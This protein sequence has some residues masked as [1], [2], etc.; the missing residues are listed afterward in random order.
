M[1][2]SN[3]IPVSWSSPC[4]PKLPGHLLPLFCSTPYSSHTQL[5]EFLKLTFLRV[6]PSVCHILLQSPPCGPCACLSFKIQ[7]SHVCADPSSQPPDVKISGSSQ[8]WHEKYIHKWVV[9]EEYVIII[10]TITTVSHPHCRPR[11]HILVTFILRI[12]NTPWNQAS[13]D[14]SGKVIQEL[15]RGN[16]RGPFVK[17][18][19][20]LH[21]RT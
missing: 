6:I 15:H 18:G 19:S 21:H 10:A 5:L 16:I 2:F 8:G 14:R 20:E 7:L 11:D 13:L 12:Q 17:N 4:E 1:S 9:A 3:P